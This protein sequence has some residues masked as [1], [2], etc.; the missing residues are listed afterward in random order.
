MD[1]EGDASALEHADEEAE[2]EVEDR[3][4][5]AMS[6]QQRHHHFMRAQYHPPPHREGEHQHPNQ[7]SNTTTG[8]CATRVGMTSRSSTLAPRVTIANT[9]I[10]SVALGRMWINTPQGGITSAQKEHTR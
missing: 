5:V 3:E 2:A 1:G 9:G 4:D 7:T 8:T 6:H 10:R